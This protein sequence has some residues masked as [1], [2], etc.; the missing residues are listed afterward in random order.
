MVDFV[1]SNTHQSVPATGQ[2]VLLL[3]AYSGT[4]AVTGA[5][6]ARVGSIAKAIQITLSNV[7]SVGAAAITVQATNDPLA[8]SSPSTATWTTLT[9]IVSTSTTQATFTTL[10]TDTTPWNYYRANTGANASTNT[11]TVVLSF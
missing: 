5:T 7:T 4:A 2:Q 9:N 8:V 3:A 11:M 10:Y 1:T 6:S